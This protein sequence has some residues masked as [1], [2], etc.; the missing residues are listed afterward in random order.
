METVKNMA[1]TDITNLLQLPEGTKFNEETIE[2]TEKVSGNEGIG[3]NYVV[4]IRILFQD[5][6]GHEQV[7][8]HIIEYAQIGDEG[9]SPEDYELIS[10]D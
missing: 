1:L 7:K 10:F 4:K 8:E 5:S 3:I 9:L 6:H 2:I